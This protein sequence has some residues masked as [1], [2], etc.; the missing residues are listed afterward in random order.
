MLCT[1]SFIKQ[2][3]KVEEGLC[4]CVQTNLSLRYY[5]SWGIVFC[6]DFP[7]FQEPLMFVLFFNFHPPRRA[8]IFSLLHIGHSRS[9]TAII[10]TTRSFPTVRIALTNPAKLVVDE[11]L[12]RWGHIEGLIALGVSN[13]DNYLVYEVSVVTCD[14]KIA[15]LLSLHPNLSNAI[16]RELEI[17]TGWR[18]HGYVR[19]AKRIPTPSRNKNRK[20]TPYFVNKRSE[21]GPRIFPRRKTRNDSPP[22]TQWHWFQSQL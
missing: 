21:I 13:L 2:K 16:S 4:V 18:K 15:S 20:Q 9:A 19:V 1:H 10:V 17:V 6:Y 7:N 22:E 3:L 12:H 8:K 5:G 14:V 11:G